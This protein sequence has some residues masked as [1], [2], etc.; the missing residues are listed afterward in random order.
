MPLNSIQLLWIENRWSGV[1]V[2]PL[3]P[4][5]AIRKLHGV[6]LMLKKK[7]KTK[8]TLFAHKSVKPV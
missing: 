1:P 6:V 7:K 2:A 3:S 4:L 8:Q 5:Q